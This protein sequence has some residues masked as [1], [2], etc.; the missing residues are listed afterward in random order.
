MYLKQLEIF[1]QPIMHLM[2]IIFQIYSTNI[3]IVMLL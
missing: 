2:F 1:P 3:L